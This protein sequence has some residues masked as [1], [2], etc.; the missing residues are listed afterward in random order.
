MHQK[1]GLPYLPCV[2]S[3][4]GIVRSV[5]VMA[6]LLTLPLLGH[7]Q[8]AVE[9]WRLVASPVPAAR[10][11]QIN[12]QQQLQQTLRQPVDLYFDNEPPVQSLQ[13]AATQ[14][15]IV[16]LSEFN[17][18]AVGKKPD[19]LQHLGNLVPLMV[20]FEM[21]WCL[22]VQENSPLLQQPRVN[23][24]EW[25]A[26]Q[27]LKRPVRVGIA[28]QGGQSMFWLH[29]LTKAT[30]SEAPNLHDIVPVPYRGVHNQEEA[31]DN[32][33]D[34][35]LANCWQYNTLGRHVRLLATAQK[36]SNRLLPATPLFT[37]LKLP[38]LAPSWFAAF[39]PKNTPPAIQAQAIQALEKVAASPSVLQSIEATQQP[40]LRWSHA[41]SRKYIENYVTTWQSVMQLL[42]WNAV[43]ASLVTTQTAFN[44]VQ[45]AK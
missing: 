29:V 45:Q 43:E 23:V 2:R 10:A 25:M 40:P 21:P 7:S 30:H 17:S 31:W 36:S 38:P 5:S 9:H 8:N 27:R 19:S 20:F 16:L 1:P 39:M 18:F 41:Q 24:K 4:Q 28:A 33:A 14:P 3:I 35:A 6:A 13:S 34:I 37:D 22:Y 42:Q 12:I 11:L 26:E 44:H 15:L 32:D